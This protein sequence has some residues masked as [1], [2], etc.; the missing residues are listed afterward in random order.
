MKEKSFKIINGNKKILLSAPHSVLH[1][2][3]NNIRASETRTRDLVKRISSESNSYGIYKIKPEFNDANWDKKCEYKNKIKEIVKK[4]KIKA[5]I[6]I[7]GMAAY[8]KQDICIGINY[9]K[10]IKNNYNILNKIIRIFNKKG[11]E[12]ITIDEPFAASYEY[13]VS[14][15]IAQKCDIITFQ[16]EINRKYRSSSYEE[17]KKY[18]NLK[19]S[20]K[21]IVD[22][23]EKEL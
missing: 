2:R 11:F 4:E 1:Q 7:H 23:L 18:S 20:I 5:L 12:N 6:D 3:Q 13:C 17:Y 8:R 15:Y 9:G 16:I 21:E 14:T 19:E 10:N 22:F